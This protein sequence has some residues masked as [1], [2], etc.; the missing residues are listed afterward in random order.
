MMPQN[1]NS[2]LEGQDSCLKVKSG[3][4]IT[5]EILMYLANLQDD[6]R[7]F[8]DYLWLVTGFT[9]VPKLFDLYEI[10]PHLSQSTDI[11]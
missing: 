2:Y 8:I 10:I 11:F 4:T 3:C 9:P 1:K 7:S 6:I 5:K